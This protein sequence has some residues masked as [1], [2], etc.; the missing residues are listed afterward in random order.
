MRLISDKV[1]GEV[2]SVRELISL[3]PTIEVDVF[4]DRYKFFIQHMEETF[5]SLSLRDLLMLYTN[6]DA[7]KEIYSWNDSH[8]FMACIEFEI[9]K[10][11]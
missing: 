10:M 7:V 1:L 2:S 9:R 4:L 8:R 6:Q 11:L 3:D 5:P